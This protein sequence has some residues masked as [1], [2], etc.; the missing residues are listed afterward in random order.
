MQPA[1]SSNAILSRKARLAS[2]SAGWVANI[3]EPLAAASAKPDKAMVNDSLRQA[4]HRQDGGAAENAQLQRT[5]LPSEQRDAD[6]VHDLQRRIGPRGRMQ[7]A[8]HGS[9]GA[10]ARQQFKQQAR[11]AP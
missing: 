5:R 3:N 10:S 9:A 7:R 6:D 2:S 1:R 11:C 8:E 4:A